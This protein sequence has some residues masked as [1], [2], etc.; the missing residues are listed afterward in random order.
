MSTE[1]YQT[2]WWC[3]YRFNTKEFGDVFI[4]DDKAIKFGNDQDATIE[5]DED[6][7]DQLKD[8]W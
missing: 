1:H 4:A 7:D 3:R 2:Q 6:G 5:Y 8:W